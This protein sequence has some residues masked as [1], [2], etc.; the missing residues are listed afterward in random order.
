M[1]PE[2]PG[3]NVGENVGENIPEFLKLPPFRGPEAIF[4]DIFLRVYIAVPVSAAR[5]IRRIAMP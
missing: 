2:K 4:V 3:D 1:C 5:A